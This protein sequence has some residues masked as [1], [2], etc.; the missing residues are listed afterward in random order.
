MSLFKR[1]AD[2]NN[3]Q[4][5]NAKKTK[6]T[7]HTNTLEFS[8]QRRPAAITS[9]PITAKRPW[10]FGQLRQFGHIAVVRQG[11]PVTAGDRRI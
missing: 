9:Q 10:W 8:T 1:A 3:K 2:N 5:K 6:K 7:P 4:Q 11:G